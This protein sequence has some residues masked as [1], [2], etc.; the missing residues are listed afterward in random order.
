MSYDDHY[1]PDQINA[2]ARDKA[3]EDFGDLQHE[4]AG[5]V[6]FKNARFMDP[7]ERSRRAGKNGEHQA[8]LS[9]LHHMMMSTAY[10]AAY[11]ETMSALSGAENTVYEALLE[12]AEQI[13]AAQNDLVAALGG[14]PT[15]PDGT[16]VFRAADGTVHTEDGQKV[17]PAVA[18][19]IEWDDST[20]SWKD[21]QAK[22][23]ALE[24]AQAHHAT[25]AGYDT[26]LARIRERMEDEDNPP[27]HEEIDDYKK[28][29]GEIESEVSR[30]QDITAEIEVDRVANPAALNLDLGGF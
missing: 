6:T 19:T 16:K 17:D 15:L 18:A 9:R 20:P 27:T 4:M 5:R 8:Y 11:T 12:A 24:D 7:H 14:A 2:R 22:K 10:R 25:L 13:Q 30:T 28:R 23:K 26:E 29:I 3:R 21:Y 1:S